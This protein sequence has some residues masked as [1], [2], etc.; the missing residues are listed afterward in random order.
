MITHQ[1]YRPPQW[2]Q[3]LLKAHRFQLNCNS[4]PG[5]NRIC[6]QTNQKL[7]SEGTSQES[8]CSP[9]A[10]P[11][12]Q[13]CTAVKPRKNISNKTLWTQSLT[14]QGLLPGPRKVC[15]LW[16]R[17]SHVPGF[18]IPLC[19][20]ISKL[21]NLPDVQSLQKSHILVYCFQYTKAKHLSTARNCHF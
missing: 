11:L 6:L 9:F 21:I 5:S 15:L 2:L 7:Q 20:C 18:N 4:E 1:V 16:R 14:W 17:G 19:N 3:L 13:Q 8:R 12:C 10:S